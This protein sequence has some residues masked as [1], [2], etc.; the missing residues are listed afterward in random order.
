MG[1]GRLPS[2]PARDFD[3]RCGA[4]A[5]RG[6]DAG[7]LLT[8]AA[9]RFRPGPSPA[10]SESHHGHQMDPHGR[11][12]VRTK[13]TD[14]QVLKELAGIAFASRGGGVTSDGMHNFSSLTV[15]RWATVEE[16]HPERR[17]ADAVP[18]A[19]SNIRSIAARAA[20]WSAPMWIG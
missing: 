16:I 19:A 2:D 17:G 11:T 7:A 4:A 10:G 1:L 6:V 14:D 8:G 15:D 12:A 18:G 20:L 9:P 13:I 3:R 5:S